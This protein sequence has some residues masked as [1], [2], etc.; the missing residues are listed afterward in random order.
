MSDA[1]DLVTLIRQH[2]AER[3]QAPVVGFLAD[4][5]DIRGGVVSW[6]YEQLDRA[7]R[8]YA[9]WMQ[10]RL[11]RG[12]RVLLLHPNGLDFVAAFY[13]CIYAAMIAVPAPLPGRHRHHRHRVATISTDADVS[14]VLTTSAH[15][16]EVRLW[17]EASGLGH[18][19]IASGDEPGFGNP[20]GW[21]AVPPDRAAP[22][23]LQYT[24][25]ST[26]DPK[27]VV[28]THDNILYNLRSCA[29][30]L[31][32]PE[33]WRVGGWVPLYH[34]LAMQGLLNMTVLRGSYVL[35]MEPISFVRHPVRWLRTM[36]E[37]DLQVTFAP[38]FAYELCT[39]RIS[40]D[41][42][43]T[44]DL[45]G[46]R[47][48]GNASEPVNPAVLKAFAGKFAPAGFRPEVFAP[49]YGMAEATGYIAGEVGREPVVRVAGL[50]PGDPVREITGC[51]TPNEACEIRVV[52]P[53]SRHVRP[54]GQVGEIWVRGRSVAP[55]YWNRTDAAFDAVTADGE[56]GFLRTG[57]LGMLAD[58]ELYVYGRLKETLIVRGRNLY[59]QDVEQELRAQ[60]PE[61]GRCGAVFSGQPAGAGDA[62]GVIVTHEVTNVARDRLPELA[63]ELR[64]TVGREFGVQVS[65]VVLLRPGA[66]LRT[67][68]GKIRRSAMRELFHEGRLAALY[69]HPPVPQD[70]LPSTR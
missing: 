6:T 27:G 24:S 22:A 46:W 54:G 29:R 44:L 12:S 58:G 39:E 36:A 43:A 21:T 45:S 28:V 41:E 49:I 51:G 34:D 26:G 68:S 55:G 16:G 65:T 40:D 32:W 52:D 25:G 7:A 38:N 9:A 3:P 4:P 47:I 33:Q 17:A 42:V 13:G 20:A 63:A 67:T 69:Q 19:P 64:H 50:A 56:G 18:L 31:D 57:D 35:L 48:A 62:Q 8:G 15:L 14:A 70:T 59:P 37:H 61:L 5:D 10:E 1:P 11:P 2:V 53:E 66:V 60:H 23:L 30:G